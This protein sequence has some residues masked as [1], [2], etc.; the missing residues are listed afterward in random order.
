MTLLDFNC[1]KTKLIEGQGET[2]YEINKDA[3]NSIKLL[4]EFS[5]KLNAQIVTIC[6]KEDKPKID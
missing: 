1:I 5:E 4:E 2:I 6:T 3:A